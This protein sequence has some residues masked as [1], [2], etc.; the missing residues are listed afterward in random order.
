[1]IMYGHGL[2]FPHPDGTHLRHQSP[3]VL[4]ALQRAV[5]PHCPLWVWS[6]DRGHLRGPWNFGNSSILFGP[7]HWKHAPSGVSSDQSSSWPLTNT[8]SHLVQGLLFG[9]WPNWWHAFSTRTCPAAMHT[10]FSISWSPSTIAAPKVAPSRMDCTASRPR[11]VVIQLSTSATVLSHPFWYSTWKLNFAR[12]ATHQWPV[13]SK[14]EV[15]IIYVRGL[16]SVLTK[17]GWYNKYSLK[18]S[19][20]A[21]W[22]ILAPGIW[23][24]WNDSSFHGLWVLSC[25]RA[26]R[27]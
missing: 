17:K 5:D 12:A 11:Q 21:W 20:M 3:N 2:D 7:P 23:V 22:P 1:M 25:C 6:A 14:L 18:C 16:L 8:I 19:M 9:L 13:A 15:V 27:W 10:S 4:L 26:T 24:Q